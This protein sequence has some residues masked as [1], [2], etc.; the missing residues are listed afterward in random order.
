MS[1]PTLPSSSSST[2]DS[3]NSISPNEKVRIFIRSPTT[4]SP[5]GFSILISP[6]SSVLILKQTIFDTHPQKPVVSDQKLIYRGKVLNDS[7]TIINV[8][9]DGLG[10]DQTFHLVV[11]PSFSP[12]SESTGAS[13]SSSNSVPLS[14][15]QRNRLPQ[16]YPPTSSSTQISDQNNRPNGPVD[17]QNL[18]YN[19]ATQQDNSQQ[20]L[21]VLFNNNL[22]PMGQP[23]Q[24]CFV[25]IK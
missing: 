13:K 17:L 23:V 1:V 4:P 25:M 9:R 19:F 12:I 22:F 5:E 21:P 14:Q 7:D 3:S 8:L 6:D 24:Y 18:Y 20:Q 15:Q 10:T 11:K 2:S 16:G